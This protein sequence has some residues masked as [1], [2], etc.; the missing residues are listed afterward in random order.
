[1]G[2]SSYLR[3]FLAITLGF[4][5]MHVGSLAFYLYSP[6]SFYHGA[7]EYIRDIAYQVKGAPMRWEGPE[8]PD[9]SRDNFF[10][11]RYPETIKFTTDTDGF[12][13]T[14][15]G[16]ESYPFVVAG[17]STIFG[18]H[19][20]DEN[21]LPWQLSEAIG[22]PVFNGG[23]AK[24]SIILGHPKLAKLEVFIDGITERAIFPRILNR[25]EKNIEKGTFQPL[26]DKSLSILEA[27]QEVPPQR[28]SLPLIALNSIEKLIGDFKTWRTGGEQPKLYLRHRML[29]SE[30]DQTIAIITTR[31]EAFDSLG[32]RYVFLPIPAK[33]NL[34]ADN[35]DDYTRNFLPVLFERLAEENIEFIDLYTP[36]QEHKDEELFYAYDT[37]WNKKGVA[38]AAKIIADQLAEK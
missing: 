31:K 36:F 23:F 4:G 20:S 5:A 18:T 6:V 19:L 1:M 11:Y 26:A 10:Y 30:L 22:R 28:Y 7:N 8:Y 24:P 33:Q 3:I 13:T 12:R 34:Y 21:T 29:P 14:K 9:L 35:V 17:D 32:I 27:V 15:P 2:N 16:A 25:G 38:L 37:H